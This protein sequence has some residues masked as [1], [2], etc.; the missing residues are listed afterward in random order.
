MSLG[1]DEW[2]GLIRDNSTNA[3]VIVSGPVMT[4]IDPILLGA[5]VSGTLT[6]Q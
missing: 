6:K 1:K 2:T 3:V 4:T 5:V